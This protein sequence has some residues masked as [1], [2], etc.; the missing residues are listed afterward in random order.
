[1]GAKILC[2]VDI[3]HPEHEKLLLQRAAQLA[4][5]DEAELDI[6]TVIPGFGTSFVGSYFPEGAEAKMLA[7]ANTALHALV[8][9]TLGSDLDTKVRHIVAEGTVYM[10]ILRI[11][12]EV[13][14]TLIVIG[15]H[16]PDLKDFLL[17]PNADRIS[18]HASCS[19]YIV[20]L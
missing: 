17:G 6:V 2:A 4:G 14:A 18:R 20:R 16:R 7:D 8:T 19:V 10:E 12:E 5:L 9:D 11:A 3:G 13:N 15:S 1:V